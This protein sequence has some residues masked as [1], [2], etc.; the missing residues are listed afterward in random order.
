ML[1]TCP[2]CSNQMTV[3]AEI[4]ASGALQCPHCDNI[5]SLA[6]PAAR[7]ARAARAMP[8]PATDAEEK[9]AK[10]LSSCL[11]CFV[12]V[13]ACCV[14]FGVIQHQNQKLA[15][16]EIAAGDKFF[17]EGKKAEAVAK[18]KSGFS[19]APADRK[20]EIIKRSADIEAEAGNKAEARHWVE[21]GLNANLDITYSTSAARDVL[22]AIRRERVEAEAQRVAAEAKKKE[23]AKGIKVTAE[24]IRQDYQTDTHAAESKYK[25]KIFRVSGW[26]ARYMGVD[27]EFPNASA[28]LFLHEPTGDTIVCYNFR[29]KDAPPPGRLATGVQ[30]TVRGRC[31]GTNPTGWVR[32]GKPPAVKVDFDDCTIE[33]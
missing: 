25:G 32:I 28:M 10:S 24:Q 6:M 16:E 12:L 4:A 19:H 13:V 17:A 2:H 3:S 26:V 1:V 30:V 8:P 21:Q 14:V 29:P 22:D 7:P 15:L 18:Y 11:G 27:P 9:E 20:S 33:P 31:A 5:L 23:D